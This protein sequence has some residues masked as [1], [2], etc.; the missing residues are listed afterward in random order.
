MSYPDPYQP[1]DHFTPAPPNPPRTHRARNILIGIAAVFVALI[2]LA[3]IGSAIGEDTNKNTA[4]AVGATSSTAPAGRTTAPATV[5]VTP[6]PV[7]ITAEPTT[8]TPPPPPAAPK[9]TTPRAYTKD[10]TYKVGVE[11]QPGEYSYIVDNGMLSSGYYAICSAANC[12]LDTIID[13]NFIPEPGTTGYLL[14]PFDAQYI[15]LQG[16][17]LT[18]I[19]P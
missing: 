7:T 10:G 9:T 16:L 17:T 1:A 6:P 3:A 5:T 14:I 13:N 2:V 11:I 15:E 8:Q 4:K 18:P 19:N 12:D